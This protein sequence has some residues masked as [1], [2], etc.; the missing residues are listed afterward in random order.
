MNQ[1]EEYTYV[2]I[3]VAK[4]S[5]EVKTQQERFTIGND[6]KGY[7]QLSKRLAKMK[8]PMVVFEATGGYERNL[9]GYLFS[10]SIALVR[11]NPT[12]IRAFAKSES[13]K[14]KNDRI[15]AT[16][17][18]RFAQEK[19]P[20]P[21]QAPDPDRQHMA[22][23]LDRRSHLTE[24]LAREKNRLQMAPKHLQGRIKR[25]I[26]FIEKEI[27]W[28]DQQIDNLIKANDQLKQQ[29]DTIKSVIGVGPITS[30]SILAYLP[31]IDQLNR[32]QVV[33]LAGLAPFDRDSATISKK[34]TIQAGRAKVRKCLF[35]AA[36]SAALHN[37]VIKEYV[38]RH[39][40][41]EKPYKWL[42]T[43]A[44]RKLLIHIHCRLK[45][46]QLSLAS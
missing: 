22:D 12:L 4:A 25:M 31:E 3:D 36:Q 34:R 39:R 21:A 2:A 43:A 41:R 32:N 7:A 16:M 40:A 18:L 29:N 30:W 10:K 14:A 23:L 20:E 38:D 17:I 27:D 44:M 19:R 26:R 11:I 28:I 37:P 15:D 35:M 1:K 8:N 9:M 13:V 24:Q 42:M 6:A 5:L 33:A 46:P 45:N